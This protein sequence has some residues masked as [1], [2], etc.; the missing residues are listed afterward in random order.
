M[1]RFT[2]PI[3]NYYAAEYIEFTST[4]GCDLPK[5]GKREAS[6]AS[7][8]STL[9]QI[10]GRKALSRVGV[11]GRAKLTERLEGGTENCYLF[12]NHPRIAIAR[13]S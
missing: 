11:L 6:F 3:F 9:R 10:F 8:E 5:N 12:V 4:F 7:M 13:L 2:D 1:A